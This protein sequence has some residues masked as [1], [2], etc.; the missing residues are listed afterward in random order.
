MLGLKS[1]EILQ[2]LKEDCENLQNLIT[3]S[4]IIQIFKK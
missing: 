3:N 1:E 4:Q 2:K